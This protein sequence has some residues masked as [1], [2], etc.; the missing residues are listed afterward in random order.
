MKILRTSQLIR[1]LAA[2]AVGYVLLT[3]PLH[4]APFTYSP[5]DL[6]LAFRN[7]GSSSNL[8]VNVG[9]ATNFNYLPLGTTVAV[10]N[11]AVGQLN[12]AF[13]SLNSLAWSVAAANRPPLVPGYPL[14]TLWVTAPRLD[15]NTPSAPWLRKGSYTQGNPAGQ[16]NSIGVN[17]VAFSSGVASNALNTTV[18]VLIPVSSDYALTPVLGEGNYVGTF[19]GNVEATT[20]ASFS[21]NPTNVSRSDLYE[22]LPGSFGTDTPGRYLGY[23]EF[24]PDGSLTFNAPPS[25]V[26]LT[27]SGSQSAT[28]GDAVTL[29]VTASNATSFQWLLNGT[30]LVGATSSNYALASVTVANAGDY[31]VIVANPYASVTSTVATLT[32]AKATPV[33]TW[34]NPAGLTY[35]TA[36]SSVQL[37]ATASVPGTFSYTPATGAV[38]NASNGQV[39]SVLFTPSDTGNYNTTNGSVTINVARAPLSVT[40][41]NASRAFGAANPVFSGTLTSV[42]NGDNITANYASSATSGSAVGTYAIVPTLVDPSGRLANYTATINNG[43]LTIAPAFSYSPGDLVLALRNSGSSSNLVVNVGK[44]TNFN[45]LPLGTTVAVGSLTVGQL[46]AAFAS[47]NSLSWSVAAA[48]RPPLVPGYP[49]QTLWVTAPRQDPN[50]PSAPWLPASLE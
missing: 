41:G 33:L 9:A 44:A 29:T 8:V 43:V 48:N 14:Q 5:G 40:A 35:G 46:N 31:Q 38:L 36:L 12:A 19:Q 16:I 1:S 26:L 30:N 27:Q 3:G 42:L 25:P 4:A 21:G 37:N 24:K 17:A 10:S 45:H 50:T 39:L 32:V 18:G 2:V 11:L 20:S 7:S 6:V 22:L 28:V 47:L 15:P 49:L 13:A 34:A 23:F